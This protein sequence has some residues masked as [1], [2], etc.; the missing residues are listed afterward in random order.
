MRVTVEALMKLTEAQKGYI[1]GIVD[2]EGSITLLRCPPDRAHGRPHVMGFLGITNSS[3]E[4]LELLQSW[5]G[6]NIYP[7]KRYRNERPCWLLRI[8]SHRELAMLLPTLEPYL[9][10]KRS[11]AILVHKFVLSR[12]SK[13]KKGSLSLPVDEYE[14]GL[15]DSVRFLNRTKGG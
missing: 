15:V 6:G 14:W 3:R 4:M 11:Q 7:K 12:L 13:P 8:A 2:G 9:V 1:A 10:V 5:I